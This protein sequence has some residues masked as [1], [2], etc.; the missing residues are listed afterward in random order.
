[1]VP[2]VKLRCHNQV[3]QRPKVNLDIGMVEDSLEADNDDIG[4][5]YPLGA[6]QQV[7]WHKDQGSGKEQLQEMLTR[8]SDP[9]HAFD[10]MVHSMQTP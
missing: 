7:D 2:V 4:I 8:P 3:F 5:H 10:A 6:T 9:V 1:M